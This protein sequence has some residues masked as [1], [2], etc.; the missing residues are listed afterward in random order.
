M[1]KRS[2]FFQTRHNYYCGEES[3]PYVDY[4]WKG[5]GKSLK[6]LKYLQLTILCYFLSSTNPFVLEFLFFPVIVL[7]STVMGIGLALSH[8]C[9]R[10]CWQRQ[11]GESA[12]S[13]TFKCRYEVTELADMNWNVNCLTF[14]HNS[15]IVFVK[16]RWAVVKLLHDACR[17]TTGR[18][19]ASG[20]INC[21]GVP[22]ECDWAW[23]TIFNMSHMDLPSVWGVR[24]FLH[25]KA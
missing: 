10:E 19:D 6:I 25:C 5:P 9:E 3:P 23:N 1:C 4:N 14:L 13:V 17:Q 22:Q 2:W 24:T 18:T 16:I 15:N 7:Q 20:D 12:Q 8:C 21:L 11:R